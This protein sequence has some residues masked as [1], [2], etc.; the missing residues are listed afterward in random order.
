MGQNYRVVVVARM[1]AAVVVE[2]MGHCHSLGTDRRLP[3][4]RNPEP[5]VLIV[6]R[7]IPVVRMEDTSVYWRVDIDLAVL[8]GTDPAVLVHTDRE[9]RTDS[10]LVV[11]DREHLDEE[12]VF[13]FAATG[14]V[15]DSAVLG[16]ADR[17]HQLAA[18]VPGP[19]ADP[20]AHIPD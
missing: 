11:P 19:I 6:L 13:H 7:R 17:A 5:A 20:A 3:V 2:D 8:A 12:I 1:V 16:V 14:V 9:R 10:L 18:A 4:G 15:V